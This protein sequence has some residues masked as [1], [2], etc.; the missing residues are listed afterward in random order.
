MQKAAT[1]ILVSSES[2]LAKDPVAVDNHKVFSA[3]VTGNVHGKLRL[4]SV[5]EALS[6][7]H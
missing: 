4:L 3:K 1:L 2:N 5:P 7:Q 6:K